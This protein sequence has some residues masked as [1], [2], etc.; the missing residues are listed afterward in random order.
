MQKK[1]KKTAKF[2]NKFCFTFWVTFP[3]IMQTVLLFAQ[4]MINIYIVGRSGDYKFIDVVG[5]SNIIIYFVVFGTAII[6][7]SVLE[8]LV[9]HALAT[10]RV[11]LSGH[12]LNRGL[13]LWTVLFAGVLAA[14][15]NSG[16]MLSHLLGQDE[17][18]AYMTQEYLVHLCPALWFWGIC[19][20]Y[21]RFFN[22]FHKFWTPCFTYF[23]TVVMVHPL[24][25]Y[26]IVVVSNLGAK[27]LAISGFITNFLTYLILRTIQHCNVRMAPASFC[28]TFKTCCN[29]C[30]Y[31]YY[32]IP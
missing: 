6:F 28:P 2:C 7:N 1:K 26:Q 29:L 31:L 11:E 22:C 12:I 23:F 25:C 24:V 20:A 18:D 9:P 5:M 30:Q 3:S 21:R 32:G 19:D 8:T 13:F 15:M 4:E 14:A 17:E 10:N 27:G 16:L